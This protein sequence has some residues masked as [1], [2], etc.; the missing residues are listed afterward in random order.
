[1]S[2][3]VHQTFR[4][5]SIPVQE[6]ATKALFCQACLKLPPNLLPSRGV[7]FTEA[8][9]GLAGAGLRARTIM[10]FFIPIEFAS[11]VPL[12]LMTEWK[13]ATLF[14]PR[15]SAR[16]LARWP[17]GEPP[18]PARHRRVVKVRCVGGVAI[19]GTPLWN[20]TLRTKGTFALLWS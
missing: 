12:L 8:D 20:I 4:L 3:K 17:M 9:Y 13:L 6:A 10:P 2:T 5:G 7:G 14:L 15:P 11:I 18:S 16:V 19:H 1:V